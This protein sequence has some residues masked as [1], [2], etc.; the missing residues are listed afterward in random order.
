[1]HQHWGQGGEP[2]ETFLPLSKRQRPGK[3]RP[4]SLMKESTASR[5]RSGISAACA[6]FASVISPASL[7]ACNPGA[8][9]ARGEYPRS[10]IMPSGD[11]LAQTGQEPGHLLKSQVAPHN[12]IADLRKAH[13]RPEGI[14]RD[15]PGPDS[16][17]A[18]RAKPQ[19]VPAVRKRSSC[20]GV[21]TA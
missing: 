1:M 3:D 5:H 7:S 21:N 15:L 18:S 13:R 14:G 17:L 4:Q 20:Q 9:R 10:A 16:A 19:Y 2:G 11:Q 8:S 12:A 6:Q